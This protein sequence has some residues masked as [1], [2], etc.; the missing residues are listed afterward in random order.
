MAIIMSLL[1]DVVQTVQPPKKNESSFFKI[2][3]DTAAG[4]GDSWTVTNDTE[5]NKS[6]TLYKISAI[7]DSTIV[8]DFTG[9][10]VTT[11]SAEMMGMQ[12]TTTMN[13]KI[14]GQIILDKATGIIRQ[15]NGTTESSGTTEAMGG[16]LPVTS[17]V[18]T[19]IIVVPKM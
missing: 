7:T 10:S 12:T 3:P 2:L 11:T 8:V 4:I 1:S 15:K 6:A 14:T 9:N 17:T 16:Q 5:S 13:N 19:T 18:A